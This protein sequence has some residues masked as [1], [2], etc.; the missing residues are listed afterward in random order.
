MAIEVE[1]RSIV[2]RKKY[3]GMR[4][5]LLA[6]GAEDLGR[7]DTETIF[8]VT[9]TAQLKV[10]SSSPQNEAKIAWKSGG[11]DGAS[12][13]EE[14]EVRINFDDIASAEALIDR[15]MRGA[16]KVPT[17]QKRHDYRIG[18]LTVAVKYSEH[19]GYHIEIDEVVEDDKQVAG[20]LQHIQQLADKLG[21]T[22]LTSAE[23]KALTD[24]MLA[25][26]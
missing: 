13:R 20:A 10:Q 24:K 2:T 4:D 5:Q 9:D 11:L 25:T 6:L 12:A 26:L 8:Y 14:I 23:E 15:L 19:W 16:K 21:V 7:K 22:L 17:S 18:E 1:K 3:E